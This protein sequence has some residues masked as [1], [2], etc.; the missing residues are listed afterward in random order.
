MGKCSALLVNKKYIHVVQ[1][2]L[3]STQLFYLT[4]V[5]YIVIL[6]KIYSKRRKSQARVR[7]TH[8]MKINLQINKSY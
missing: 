5:I 8:A 3:N 2:N 7:I 1:L 6:D 4:S